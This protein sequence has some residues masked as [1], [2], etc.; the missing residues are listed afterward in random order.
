MNPVCDGRVRPISK[1]ATNQRVADREKH[2][3]NAH[4]LRL[5]IQSLNRKLKFDGLTDSERNDIREDVA[6]KQTTMKSKET[7]S[8]NVI[9]S[10]FEEKL[11]EELETTGAH[12]RNDAGGAV[13]PVMTAEFQADAVIMGRLNSGDALMALTTTPIFPSSPATGPWL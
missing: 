7:R 4:S 10:N 2:R 1:Q 6:K 3:I 9:Q 12:A 13:L 11:V 5:E 8:Q